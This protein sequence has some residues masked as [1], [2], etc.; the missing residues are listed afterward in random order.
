MDVRI[1]GPDGWKLLHS[2]VENYPNHPNHKDR[3]NMLLFFSSIKY[4]LPCIYCRR[5]FTEYGQKLPITDFLESKD[6]LTSWI[7]QI[8]EFV[9]NKLRGQD[10]PVAETPSYTSVREKYQRYIKE[11]NESNC[12]NMDG[13][14]FIYCALFNFP[15]DPKEQEDFTVE[16]HAGY[17]TF[18]E[19]LIDVLPFTKA[20]NILMTFKCRFETDCLGTNCDIDNKNV[21][22]NLQKLAYDMEHAVK[23]ATRCS[24]LSYG[25]RCKEIDSYRAKCGQLG[26]AQTCRIRSK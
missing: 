19:S 10:L 17:I 3:E 21:G 9:N 14:T 16:R 20:K 4:I 8:H 25:D 13:W 26:K 23:N 12:K 2:I 5:S 11:V 7:Y 1:W 24:C 6:T 22:E 15:K 18:L